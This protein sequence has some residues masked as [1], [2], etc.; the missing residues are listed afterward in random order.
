MIVLRF[1]SSPFMFLGEHMHVVLKDL[2]GFNHT[3]LKKL[4]EDCVIQ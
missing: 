2:K 1:E 4:T 3:R